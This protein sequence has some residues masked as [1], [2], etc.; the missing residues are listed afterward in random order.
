MPPN[1]TDSEFKLLFAIFQ[2]KSLLIKWYFWWSYINQNSSIL[3]NICVFRLW[4]IEVKVVTE[5]FVESID[6]GVA[7][8]EQSSVPKTT[9]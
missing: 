7:D 4:K 6:L 5:A 9:K 2:L 8:K 1:G 3:R